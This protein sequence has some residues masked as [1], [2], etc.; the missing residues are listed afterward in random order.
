MIGRLTQTRLSDRPGDVVAD[1][2]PDVDPDVAHDV[3][4]DVAHAFSVPCRHSWRHVSLVRR[5]SS[6]PAGC[7]QEC[8]HSTLKAC[9][10]SLSGP[11]FSN[12][13]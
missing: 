1:V 8:R 13:L 7:R 4:P 12:L 6:R 3:G 10:T 9:A 5:V 2:V 11:A